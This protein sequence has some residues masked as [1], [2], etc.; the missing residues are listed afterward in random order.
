MELEAFSGIDTFCTAYAGDPGTSPDEAF[1]L[2]FMMKEADWSALAAA[3]NDR[4]ARW[5]EGCVYILGHG[6]A[7]LCVPILERAL[8]DEDRAVAAEAAIGYAELVLESGQP[9]RLSLAVRQ[10]LSELLRLSSGPHLEPLRTLLE[11][12]RA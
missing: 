8:F 1:D 3:W 4:A 5:R 7:H 12:Q 10:Q 6:P 9:T 2:I 11:S